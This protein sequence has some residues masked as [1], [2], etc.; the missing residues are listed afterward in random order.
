MKLIQDVVYNHIGNEHYLFTDIPDSSWFHFWPAYTRTNYRA[1]LLMDRY[2][3]AEEKKIFTDG[4]FDKH[5]PDLNQKNA[6]LAKYLVQ[7][8]LWWIEKYQIDALRIDT[9]AYPDQD[10][11]RSWGEQIKAAYPDIFL[12]AETWVHGPT[13]Q[14]WFIGSGLA[15][16]EN[17][18]D[19]L[20]DFQ[21]YYSINEALTNKQGWTEGISKLYYTL[22]ADYIYDHP[23]NMVTF[24]DNHDLARFVGYVNSDLRKVKMGLGLLFTMR[25]IPSIYYGTE[26]LMH[27]TNGHGKIRED[28]MGGWSTDSINK[29]R[30]NGRTN[31]ENAIY[32]Y[33]RKLSDFRKSNV[34]ISAGKTTQFIPVDGLYV[35]FRH[36]GENLVMVAV[37]TANEK[38]TIKKE[39]YTELLAGKTVL[40]DLEG[41]EKTIEEEMEIQPFEILI[42]EVK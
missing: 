41:Y 19:G 25:G 17:Y 28:F 26:V 3:S 37:N 11:M 8:S 31:D 30:P 13:V 14:G 32:D 27:E 9:Y 39:K 2:A 40:L 22:A 29:F 16:E 24:L 7:Q 1:P 42:F 18:L 4:W 10:F 5:M 23:E 38:R 33:I 20:T 34:A 35:Y 36:S 21:V 6:H 12:F 15:P